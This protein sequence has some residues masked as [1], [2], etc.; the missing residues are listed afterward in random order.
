MQLCADL[1]E[2][3][4]VPEFELKNYFNYKKTLSFL[5]NMFGFSCER[6]KRCY[7]Y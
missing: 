6:Q 7:N 1:T 3:Q 4:L 2:M 5:E